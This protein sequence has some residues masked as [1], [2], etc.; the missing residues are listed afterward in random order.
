MSATLKLKKRRGCGTAQNYLP[1]INV[2]SIWHLV[3]G[4]TGP[5]WQ[6]IKAELHHNE[7]VAWG[8][9]SLCIQK[10]SHNEN[11]FCS[12]IFQSTFKK[13]GMHRNPSL[14][15]HWDSLTPPQRDLGMSSCL[16][17]SF[18]GISPL[19][20]GDLCI[21][22][23]LGPRVN[24]LTDHSGVLAW[25]PR[26]A[27][28]PTD[29]ASDQPGDRDRNNRSKPLPRVSTVIVASLLSKPRHHPSAKWIYMTGCLGWIYGQ[30][31]SLVV[32][33]NLSRTKWQ[34]SDSPL[35]MRS[36]THI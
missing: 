17:E 7:F 18:R 13:P 6:E 32:V 2:T 31:G 26:Q 36:K 33:V 10:W 30:W 28:A 23:A 22:M 14:L 27:G 20:F 9:L 19:F 5:G 21:Q 4:E 16:S 35:D 11:R 24:T 12:H 29:R 1:T 25:H 3:G 34:I 8:Q 15:E